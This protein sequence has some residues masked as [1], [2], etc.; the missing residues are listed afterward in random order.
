[1]PASGF[2]VGG[3]HGYPNRGV[4]PEKMRDIGPS[5]GGGD[6]MERRLTAK[7]FSDRAFWFKQAV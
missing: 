4:R 2:P 7:A 1:M 5:G 6:R 3:L